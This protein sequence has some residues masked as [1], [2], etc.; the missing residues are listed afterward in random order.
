MDWLPIELHRFKKPDTKKKA[1]KVG[2][3]P[4]GNKPGLFD[5]E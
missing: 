3:F 1:S 4:I 5:G 2:G